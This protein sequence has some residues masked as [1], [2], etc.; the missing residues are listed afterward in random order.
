VAVV[1]MTT[2]LEPELAARAHASGAL[3]FLK[4][5]FYPADIDALLTR[6]FGLSA[7]LP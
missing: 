4:K 1:M 5:P 3:A 2:T 6:H 7:P